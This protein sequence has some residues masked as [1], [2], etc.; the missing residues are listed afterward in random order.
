MKLRTI[1]KKH[2]FIVLIAATLSGCLFG[3]DKNTQEEEL[4]IVVDNKPDEITY[5]FDTV[6]VGDVYLKE[7]V[8]CEYVQTKEQEVAF[9]MG[10]K[11][12]DK[13][14]VREGDRV[15]PGDLLVEL[16]TDDIDEQILDLEYQIKRNQLMKGYLDKSEEFEKESANLSLIYSKLSGQD[17]CNYNDS[18]ESIERNYRYRREDYDDTI[19]FDTQKLNELNDELNSRQ[20]RATMS[21]TVISIKEG[22]EGSTSKRDDVIM[23]VVDSS[24]GLFSAN[25][26][27]VLGHI[28]DGETVTMNVVYGSAKGEYELTP[29]NRASWDETQLFSIVYGPDGGGL[30]VGTSGTITTILESREGVK[31]I[32]YSALYEADGRYYTYTLGADNMRQVQFIE[33]GLIGND[34]VEVLSGLEVGQQVIKK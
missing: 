32:P 18:I 10:G 26:M 1:I 12:V 3:C 16:K 19:Y 21:G 9:N 2:T 29:Y 6:T 4:I 30:E 14:Y 25:D 31:R 13:V 33:I 27:E 20:I 23:T 34:F 5:N 28:Q 7:N 11:I 17:Y 22:L 8:N 24:D 15:E